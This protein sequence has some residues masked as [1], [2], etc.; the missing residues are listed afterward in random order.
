MN[1]QVSKKTAAR[2]LSK[3]IEQ[4]PADEYQKEFYK[5]FPSTH[6]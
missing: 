6:Y 4:F 1:K 3:M 5:K 2:R